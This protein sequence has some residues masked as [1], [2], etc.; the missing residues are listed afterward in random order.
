MLSFISMILLALPMALGGQPVYG[1]T[2]HNSAFDCTGKAD[3]LA[4]IGC[5]GY[6]EC[7]GQ[8]NVTHFCTLYEYFDRDTTSCIGTTNNHTGCTHFNVCK[9][10]TDGRYPDFEKNCQTYFTCHGKNFFGHQYCPAGL[11]FDQALEICNW[12]TSVPFPCGTKPAAG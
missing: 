8:K 5:D 10:M 9:N 3:G 4:G 7:I 2:I 6:V 1:K 11:V 12:A